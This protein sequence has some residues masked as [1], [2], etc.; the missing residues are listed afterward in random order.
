MHALILK[1]LL[2]NTLSRENKTQKNFKNKCKITRK[3]VEQK[4]LAGIL[5]TNIKYK[6]CEKE[7]GVLNMY[8][9]TFWKKSTAQRN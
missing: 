5:L 8:P 4:N 9:W 7:S 6:E 3:E 1:S 2:G